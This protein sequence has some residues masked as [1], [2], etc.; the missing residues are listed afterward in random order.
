M[1]LQEIEGHNERLSI[2]TDGQSELNKNLDHL[3]TRLEE[4]ERDLENQKT[5]NSRLGV[6]LENANTQKRQLQELNDKLDTDH[7][8]LK[9]QSEAVISRAEQLENE[10]ENE[11]MTIGVLKAKLEVQAAENDGPN[12]KTKEN[13]EVLRLQEEMQRMQDRHNDMIQQEERRR[14]EHVEAA[15]RE[16]SELR[17]HMQKIQADHEDEKLR[18]NK[19]HQDH[20]LSMENVYTKKINTLVTEIGDLKLD[21]EQLR[22]EITRLGNELYDHQNNSMPHSQIQELLQFITDEKEARQSLQDLATRLTGDLESLKIQQGHM[23]PLNGMNTN[24]LQGIPDIIGKSNSTYANT[25][26]TTNDNQKGWGSRRMA[27]QSKYGRFEAQQQLNAEITAKQKVID[28]LRRTRTKCDEIEKQMVEQRRRLQHMEHIERENHVLR[29]RLSK[30]TM[31]SPSS[32]NIMIDPRYNAMQR[33]NPAF[34]N[35][36]ANQSPGSEFYAGRECI[37]FILNSNKD[38]V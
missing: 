11:R 16:T 6:E 25:P 22:T 2:L 21:N 12:A 24:S 3:K 26:L 37:V 36:I 32:P 20:I 18:W 13:A 8:Q 29:E 31:N 38:I 33:Y 4:N 28:E 5:Q 15:K 10:L 9:V 19:Q 7:Q 1:K 23:S 35:A 30:E 17:T 14:N 34:L 27:K